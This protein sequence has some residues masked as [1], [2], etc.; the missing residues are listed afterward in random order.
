P[1]CAAYGSESSW[2]SG[3][4]GVS[5]NFGKPS[6]Q[7]GC[8]VPADGKRDV[9]D[10]SLEADTAPGNYVFYNGAWN[11]VG[12]TSDAAPMMGG[13]FTLLNQKLGGSGQGLPGTRFYQLCGGSSFHDVTTGSN[14]AFSAHAG[15][16]QTTGVGTPLVDNLLN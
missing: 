10:V 3:G 7:T 9:P 14:G 12:G 2:T 8:S 15:Y 11:T 4:G 6:F 13:F 1:N 5:N 16:D